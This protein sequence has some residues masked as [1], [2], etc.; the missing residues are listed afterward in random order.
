MAI[1]GLKIYLFAYNSKTTWRA[2]LKFVHNV[3]D[4]KWFMQTEFGSTWS[5][6]Q[7]V[8]DRKWTESEQ[9]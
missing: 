8:T 1:F 5:R 7:N 4:Y 2:Q 3:G 6:D 9:F